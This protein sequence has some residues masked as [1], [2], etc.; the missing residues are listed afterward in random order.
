[1]DHLIPKS[2]QTRSNGHDHAALNGMDDT[3]GFEEFD[4]EDMEFDEDG[5]DADYDD[6]F[7]TEADE[8]L[9][10]DEAD[11]GSA[12]KR[13]H[14]TRRHAVRAG[15]PKV[16]RGSARDLA[17]EKQRRLGVLRRKLR[18]PVVRA[19]A[20][21]VRAIRAAAPNALVPFVVSARARNKITA[22]LTH[23]FVAIA[24]SQ[25]VKSAATAST[26]GQIISIP[27]AAVLTPAILGVARRFSDF[28]DD[29]AREVARAIFAALGGMT[30]ITI[31]VAKAA[32][33]EYDDDEDFESFGDLDAA[34][35][36]NDDDLE[37]DADAFDEEPEAIDPQRLRKALIAS[38]RALRQAA[39]QLLRA[40]RRL[41]TLA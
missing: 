26:A 19:T 2:G 38:R 25:A 29:E 33:S 12:A 21:Q 1:M 15:T 3:G 30:T 34:D 11:Q 23:R 8:T 27:I 18:M 37:L 5:F 9:Y 39:Q 13:R 10:L 28:D 36:W 32:T 17:R 40:E 41:N 6:G 20:P 22:L 14:T 16:R 31:R 4:R 24:L 7:D 35:D